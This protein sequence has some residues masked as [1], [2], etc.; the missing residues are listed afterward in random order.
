MDFGN[1]KF[2]LLSLK[3]SI[4]DFNMVFVHIFFLFFNEWPK[5]SFSRNSPTASFRFLF[6]SRNLSVA[7]SIGMD[8]GVSVNSVQASEIILEN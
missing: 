3:Q 4:I 2:Q 6:L 7:E 8:K 1:L 5:V